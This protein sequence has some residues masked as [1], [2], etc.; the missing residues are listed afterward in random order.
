MTG[1]VLLAAGNAAV[2]VAPAVGGAIAGYTLR[3]LDVLRPTSDSARADGNVREHACYPLLPYSNR[4][5]YARLAVAGRTIELA[6]NFGDHPHAIHGVGWQRPWTVVSRETASALIAYDHPAEGDDAIAWPWPFHAWQSFALHDDARGC[7]LTMKI[8]LRNS[9]HEAFPFG[10]GW[11]PYFRR[12]AATVLGFSA[13]GV[14][15][16]DATRIP[17]ALVSPVND[18]CFDPPHPIGATQLDNVYTGWDG[19]ASL[20]DASRGLAVEIA[21]D[22]SCPFLVVYIPRDGDFLALE[23][24]THMTD[25][26]N[27]AQQGER[28]TG[29][30][31]LGPGMAFSCTMQISARTLP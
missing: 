5:A 18:L 19:R 23:P 31:S 17:T 13:Q 24:V 4:I 15:E 20:A 14:W 21:G 16:T 12:D 3:G 30:R 2:E 29:S 22:T 1:A 8:G 11:H 10:L 26:F 27:R 25:A 7:N 9:G 6:R 28:D